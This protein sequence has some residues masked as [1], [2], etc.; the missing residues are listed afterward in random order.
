MFGKL[1]TCFGWFRIKKVSLFRLRIWVRRFRHLFIFTSFRRILPGSFLIFC[2]YPALYR[3]ALR[4]FIVL[5]RYHKVLQERTRLRLVSLYLFFCCS[6]TAGKL[7]VGSNPDWTP[8]IMFRLLNYAIYLLRT[9]GEA[10]L[11]VVEQKYTLNRN[12]TVHYMPNS[13]LASMLSMNQKNGFKYRCLFSLTLQSFISLRPRSAGKG[14][15]TDGSYQC[16][17]VEE[18]RSI[19]PFVGFGVA[20]DV[21]HLLGPGSSYRSQ[22][23]VLRTKKNREEE[24]RREFSRQNMEACHNQY[25]QYTVLFRTPEHPRTETIWAGK[26]N[27]LE[28]ILLTRVRRPNPQIWV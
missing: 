27:L 2:L 22:D 19:R 24:T 21:R 5:N 23:G 9:G 17:W 7:F 26:I 12:G 14:K 11:C 6:K 3:T 25:Q 15:L 20:L 8:E 4:N 10:L 1:N 28:N 13:T 18:G 16:Q